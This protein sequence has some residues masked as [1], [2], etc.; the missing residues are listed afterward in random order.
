MTQCTDILSITHAIF[1][2][3]EL[4]LTFHK[5]SQFCCH[6]VCDGQRKSSNLSFIDQPQNNEALQ[7]H[8]LSQDV[9]TEFNMT[10]CTACKQEHHAVVSA[11]S[12]L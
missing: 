1:R 7:Q 5:C 10:T 8:H 3:Y 12:Q 11:I 2:C 9:S 4:E 6:T